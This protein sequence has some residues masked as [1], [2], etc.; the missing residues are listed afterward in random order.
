MKSMS[1][2]TQALLAMIFG[3]AFGI[4]AGQAVVPFF[5]VIGKIF[6]NLLFMVATPFIFFSITTGVAS[7]SDLRKTGRIGLKIMLYYLGT[8]LIAALSGL[9]F[10]F[11]IGPGRGFKA[12]LSKVSAVAQKAVPSF[13]DT[14]VGMFTR[15][16]FQSLANMSLVQ[17]I[18]FAIFLGV[19]LVL[20]GDAKKPV[21]DVFETMS[22]ALIKMVEIIMKTVPVGVFALMTVT[23]AKYGVNAIASISMVLLTEYICMLLQFFV[24]FGLI[25]AFGAKVNP[26]VF[27]KR[28]AEIIMTAVSTTSSSATLPISMRTAVT[29]MGIPPSMANF[30]LPLG[31]TVNLNGAGL[32]I[33][34]CVVF[35]AQVYGVDFTIGELMYLVMITCISAVGAAGLPGSAIVFTLAILGQFGIPTEAF[36][37]IIAVY[38]LLD[39]GLTAVNITGDIVCTTA[40]AQ[41]E[42]VLDRSVWDTDKQA[43]TQETA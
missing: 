19:A 28:A 30:T 35:S 14:I 18:I 24:V 1:L 7:M 36:A 31:A 22:N 5:D 29:K 23:G 15:N 21:I 6:I 27:F 9:F 38:R 42:G 2:T 17:I 40:V 10:A 43:A 3:Y 12:D 26:F 8:T 41:S 25:L 32:N 37:L 39:M 20:L 16:I 33:A 11:L 4:F 13:G 34:I